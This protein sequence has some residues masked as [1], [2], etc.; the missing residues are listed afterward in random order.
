MLDPS[1]KSCERGAALLLFMLMLV[2]LL[3]PL[4]GL[5]IDG[6]FAYLAHARLMSA[7]DAAALAGARSLNVGMDFA[8]QKAHAEAI[9]SQYF[10]ANFPNGLFGSTNPVVSAQA[11][12]TADH[13]RTVSISV[14]ADIPLS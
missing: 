8:T 4:A 7:A 9:A 6:G 13:I 12:E 5:C 11:S 1:F 2:F 14:S 3:L 10:A